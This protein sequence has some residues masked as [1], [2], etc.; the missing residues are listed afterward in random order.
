MEGYAAAASAGDEDAVQWFIQHGQS[1]I[2]LL[3]EHI[4][5]EDHCLFTRAEQLLTD[6]D[7]VQIPGGVRPIRS[8]RPGRQ[9]EGKIPL[10]RS[11]P[12]RPLRGAKSPSV[13]L[14]STT[15]FPAG[16]VGL[17]SPTYTKH[18]PFWP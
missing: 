18:R 6:E 2:R 11:C 1:Y 14:K 17:E 10:A 13:R 16:P 3:R 5:M 7:D 8:R 15:G 12:G 4:G 9:R